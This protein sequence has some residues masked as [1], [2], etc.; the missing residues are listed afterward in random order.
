MPL[1]INQESTINHRMGQLQSSTV[2][3][4]RSQNRS[5]RVCSTLLGASQL[6]M[7]DPAWDR[8]DLKAQTAQGEVGRESGRE[9][10]CSSPKRRQ[11]GVQWSWHIF[12][13]RLGQG[14]DKKI[15][16]G[17]VYTVHWTGLAQHHEN[18]FVFRSSSTSRR[19][20]AALRKGGAF[21]RHRSR[22]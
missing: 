16:T 18:V 10:A 8:G 6:D 14:E 21:R 4:P 3:H 17:K 1:S 19:R 2:L 11:A 12:L 9:Y 20:G 15:G 22:M 7:V 13:C 5:K